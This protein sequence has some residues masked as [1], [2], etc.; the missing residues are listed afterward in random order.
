MVRFTRMFPQ[1]LFFGPPKPGTEPPTP[2]PSDPPAPD[3]TPDLPKPTDPRPEPTDPDS[4]QPQMA[5][6]WGRD[7][8]EGKKAH[9]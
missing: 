9:V 1:I 4:P 2:P 3:P 8:A 7:I 5:G 6:M